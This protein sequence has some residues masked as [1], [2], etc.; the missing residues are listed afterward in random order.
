MY[1]RVTLRRTLCDASHHRRPVALRH[2]VKFVDD[3]QRRHAVADGRQ[4]AAVDGVEM[5]HGIDD[6]D[7]PARSNSADLTEGDKPRYCD[8][9]G[10]TAGL[11]DDGVEAPNWVG[12]LDKCIIEPTTIGQATNAAPGDRGGLVD[13]AGHQTGVDIDV[14]E[15]VDHHA[16]SRVRLA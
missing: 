11:Y 7:E 4:C 9:I 13:L 1:A 14:A 6:V 16:D 2:L 12:E 15:V 5:V 10:K 3:N 8:R